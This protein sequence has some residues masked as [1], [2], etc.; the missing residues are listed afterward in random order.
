MNQSQFSERLGFTTHGVLSR[1]ERDERQP[2]VE[3]LKKIAEVFKVDLHWLITGEASPSILP[4]AERY[5]TLS[6]RMAPYV[7]QILTQTIETKTRIQREKE[8]L[9]RNIE[10]SSEQQR[11]RLAAAENEIKKANEILKQLTKDLDLLQESPLGGNS[12][13]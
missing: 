8:E 3:T 13:D 6:E 7:G 1:F 10:S 5:V 4:I 2:G 11:D 9:S 12:Y